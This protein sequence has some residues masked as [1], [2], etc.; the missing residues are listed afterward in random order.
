MLVREK[1]G[2]EIEIMT[3]QWQPNLKLIQQ[4]MER[5]AETKTFKSGCFVEDY[6]EGLG[7]QT[8][9]RTPQE[10]QQCQLTWAHGGS[11]RLSHRPKNMQSLDLDHLHICS[12]CAAWSSCGFH[13]NWSGCIL[14]LCCLPLDPFLLTGLPCLDSVGEDAFSLAVTWCARVGW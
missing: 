2:S 10:D 7:E 3:N 9:S 13:D 5:D 6:G 4:P 11:Q 8:V 1:D 12:R 14:W